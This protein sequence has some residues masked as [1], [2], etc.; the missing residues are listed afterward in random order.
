VTDR[1]AGVHPVLVAAITSVLTEMA[2]HGSP[3]MVTNGVRTVEEQKQLYAQGRT[4]PGPIVTHCDGV[5]TRSNHQPHADGF[6]H[7]VDCAFVDEHG[8]PRWVDSDPWDLYG[9]RVRAHGLHWGGLWTRP[10]RPHAELLET[11]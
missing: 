8:D 10:D 4:T 11:T 7:A 2:E 5:T 1:L 6:G 9:A 3:M